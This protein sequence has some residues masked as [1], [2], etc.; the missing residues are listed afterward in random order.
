MFVEDDK[1]QNPCIDM[2]GSDGKEESWKSRRLKI[3]SVVAH[4]LN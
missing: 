1:P 2:F 3:A 4:L